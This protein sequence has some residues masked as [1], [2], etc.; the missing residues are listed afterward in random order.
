MGM[1]STLRIAAAAVLAGS[2]AS[3]V[4]P[5]SIRLDRRFPFV[6][7]VA[8]R[9]QFAVSALA[10]AALLARAPRTRPAAAA[11]G[12][13]AVAGLGAV[14][15]RAI[16]FPTPAAAPDD[17][18]ILTFNVLNGRADTGELATLIAR[19]APHFVVLPE[20]GSD[21]RDKL[22]PLVE[23]LGYRSWVSTAPGVKDGQGV[24]L[25]AASRA[26]DVQVRS[27]TGMRLRH[28]EA[29]GGILG[30]RSLFAVHTA[31][32]V[33]RRRT[34][35]WLRDLALVE[36][37]CHG[38]V[39]PIVVGDFNATL[40]HSA[41]RAALGGCRSAAAGTGKGL[42]GTYPSSAARWAGIQIDHVLVPTGTVTTGF[43]VVEVE[44]TDHRGVLAR[45]RVPR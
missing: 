40:D 4:L 2:A 22:I 12:A 1:K 44:G 34:A 23:T 21:F 8:F 14:A 7:I 43:E 30:R 5:D 32:P 37:W 45:L 11:V 27:G 3:V 31:A 39:A 42:V 25:L 17:L 10:A 18:S 35:Q 33:D 24:T 13:V 36:R 15:A 20:A 19:E 26:G 29:T 38:P 6:D 28:L 9:P 16:P 41:F